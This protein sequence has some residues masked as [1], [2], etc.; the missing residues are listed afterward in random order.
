MK[1]WDKLSE[2]MDLSVGSRISKQTWHDLELGVFLWVKQ[3][4]QT[5]IKK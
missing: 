4:V 5:E 1:T 2:S 3:P